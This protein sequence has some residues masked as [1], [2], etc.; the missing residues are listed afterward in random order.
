MKKIFALA[1]LFFPLI[2]LAEPVIPDGDPLS[3]LLALIM[4]WKA[5]GPIALASSVVVVLVQVLKSS[6]GSFQYKRLAVV[7]LSC[8]YG[9]LQGITSGLSLFQA[10]VLA[11]VTSGGAIALYES[12]KN[13]LA[14][15][16]ND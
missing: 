10:L 6:L 12:I 13:P 1:L 7:I 11:L 16:K 9:V 8:A 3:S 5:A 14:L 15:T 4:N 2:V